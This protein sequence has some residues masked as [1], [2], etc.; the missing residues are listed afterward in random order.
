MKKNG[1]LGLYKGFWPLFW[2]DVPGWAVFFGSYE[3]IK[4]QGGLTGENENN[5][6][7]YSCCVRFA[8]GGIAG[9]L[10]WLV[11][12]PFDIVKTQIQTSD[13]RF[14]RQVFS[15]GYKEAGL[16]FFFKGMT[17]TLYR[18]I[19]IDGVTMPVFDYLNEKFVH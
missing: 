9:P 12:Y 5:F 10:S 1:P 7:F 11:T 6:D 4:N 8:A 16:N 14:M 19:L 2:R 17:A 15:K 13:E 3:W 18:G